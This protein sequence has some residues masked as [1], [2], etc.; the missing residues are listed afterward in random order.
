MTKLLPSST[1]VL[2]GHFLNNFNYYS[3]LQGPSSDRT[4]TRALLQLLRSQLYQNKS[5]ANLEQS[6]MLF[7]P[8]L[9]KRNK[10]FGFI[11]IWIKLRTLMRMQVSIVYRDM[12]LSPKLWTHA[13]QL[14]IPPS[15]LSKWQFSP[16]MLSACFAI[17]SL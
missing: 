5:L 4:G 14:L 9:F 1:F 3:T 10:I 12:C 7:S 15:H 17:K 13:V 16:I 2:Q 6:K 11:S 8:G